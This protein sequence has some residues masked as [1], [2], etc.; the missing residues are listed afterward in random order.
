VCLAIVT[1]WP[2]WIVPVHTRTFKLAIN[3]I[4]P[5]SVLE[6]IAGVNAAQGP[7][8]IEMVTIIGAAG[9]GARLVV[10][11]VPALAI[12][13]LSAEISA[14]PVERCDG[15]RLNGVRCADR[16]GGKKED[17]TRRKVST[18]GIALV[19]TSETLA[20]PPAAAISNDAL[21]EVLNLL[22]PADNSFNRGVTSAPVGHEDQVARGFD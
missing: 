1:E 16:R 7:V 15:H 14:G 20:K 19:S 22:L 18:H 11:M 3:A 4:D 6:I 2:V 21:L 13:D 12:T 5:I 9:R 17:C 8:E 10:N